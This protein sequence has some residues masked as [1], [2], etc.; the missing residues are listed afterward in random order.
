[1]PPGAAGAFAYG[2]QV[3]TSNISPQARTAAVGNVKLAGFGWVKHQ[4]EW[5]SVETAANQYDWAELDAMIQA[6]QAAGLNVMLSVEH[7]PVF[8]RSATSGLMPSDPATFQRVMQAMASRYAGKVKA[9]EM[10]NEENLARETGQGNVDPATYLPL[11]KAG[12]TG[13][14]AG[15]LERPGLPGCAESDWREPAGHFD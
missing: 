10:W 14:K 6:D 1:M 12:Y 13:T 8:Y 9:Y 5:L 15:R 7:A 4:I 3:H 11:L 2:F